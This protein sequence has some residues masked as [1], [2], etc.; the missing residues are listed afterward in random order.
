[1]LIVCPNCATSYRVT[2]KS[3]GDTGRAVRCVTCHN[4][5]FEQPRQPVAEPAHAETFDAIDPAP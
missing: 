2:P 4:V 1:M 3:L 5:W